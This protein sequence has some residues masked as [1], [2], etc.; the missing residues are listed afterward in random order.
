MKL[1][2]M[3]DGEVRHEFAEPFKVLLDPDLPDQLR[4]GSADSSAST[5]RL[6]NEDDPAQ[7]KVESSSNTVWWT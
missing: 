2:L 4:T 1:I 5:D 3:D 7:S 6:Q